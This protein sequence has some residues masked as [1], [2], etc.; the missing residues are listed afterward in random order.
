MARRNRDLAGLAALGAL[1]MY[2]SRDGKD[3]VRSDGGAPVIDRSTMAQAASAAQDA[4]F[5]DTRGMEGGIEPLG[6]RRNTESG[7]FY[8]PTGRVLGRP[9]NSSVVRPN[10]VAT[11]N[12]SPAATRSMAGGAGETKYKNP[13]RGPSFEDIAAFNRSQLSAGNTSKPREGVVQA[14]TTRSM[15]PRTQTREEAIAQ[16]PTSTGSRYASVPS[17]TDPS[18]REDSTELG[19]NIKNTLSALT[20]LGGGFAKVGA[21]LATA[22]GAAERAARSRQL[23]EEVVR[24]QKPTKFTSTKS[25]VPEKTSAATKSRV[26][27]FNEEEAGV[28]FKRGG[29][30]KVKK[31]ASGGMTSASKRADGIASRGRT[32]CKMY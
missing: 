32:K 22:K 31:M 13:Q 12:K 9:A 14:S 23:A 28:E 18:L 26:K 10:K 20:P 25:T 1:G 30:A 29:S 17:D 16:I 19:R 2:M 3:K 24:T 5:E 27:K 21:E 8:D 6:L 4:G 15:T 11:P 7:D